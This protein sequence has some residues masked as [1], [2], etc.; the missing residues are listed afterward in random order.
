MASHK[1]NRRKTKVRH[2]AIRAAEIVP[3]YMLMSTESAYRH[4]QS[5]AGSGDL[6]ACFLAACVADYL[7]E[8]RTYTRPA[9]RKHVYHD[10][11]MEVL[12]ENTG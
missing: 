9:K 11:V 12:N 8:P 7:K 2:R 10:Q 6:Q 5:Q 1:L 4:A 3:M